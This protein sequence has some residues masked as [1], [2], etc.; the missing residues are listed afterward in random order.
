[1][2]FICLIKLTLS[3]VVFSL[4]T[5]SINSN[6]LRTNNKS[7]TEGALQPFMSYSPN[8]LDMNDVSN[9]R[10]VAQRPRAQNYRFSQKN[11]KKD[12]NSDDQITNNKYKGVKYFIIF[13][14]FFDDFF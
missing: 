6:N 8:T 2:K 4:I 13:Q 7:P 1:M 5:N 3:L 11:Q 14:F 12:Y 9:M 10:S